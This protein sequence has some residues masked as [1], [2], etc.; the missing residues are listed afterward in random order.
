[1]GVLPWATGAFLSPL[2]SLST[3][4]EILIFIEHAG[5]VSVHSPG[6]SETIVKLQMDEI[7][8]FWAEVACENLQSSGV[9]LTRRQLLAQ[10]LQ[11]YERRGDA[12]RCLD[13]QGKI[14]WKASPR[15]LMMLA[16]AERDARDDLA[17]FP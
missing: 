4:A 14:A 6:C 15:F 12:L 13:N 2:S 3:F 17:E 16:D 5:A 9:N 10:I 8:R 7:L 11:Q 1:M